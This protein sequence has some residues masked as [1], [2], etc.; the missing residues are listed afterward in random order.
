MTIWHLPLGSFSAA[1]GTSSA[2]PASEQTLYTL[3]LTK[4]SKSNQVTSESS[5]LPKV[6]KGYDRK[7]KR[8][9]ELPQGCFGTNIIYLFSNSSLRRTP[10]STGLLAINKHHIV[11][12]YTFSEF[13]QT[14]VIPRHRIFAFLVEQK[15]FRI[16][17][18]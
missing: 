8:H 15:S 14:R 7:G 12:R 16:D 5:A 18:T 17:V 9:G 2:R 10:D 3:C 6:Q 4:D 1:M 11:G 13:S